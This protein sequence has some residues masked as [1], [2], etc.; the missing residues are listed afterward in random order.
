MHAVGFWHE[1]SRPDRDEH[2][3]IKWQNI[4]EGHKHNFW[5]IELSR[6]NMV[7]RYDMCSI[8]HYGLW[9]FGKYK[10]I[11]ENGRL[12]KSWHLQTILLKHE[13]YRKYCKIGIGYIGRRQN[14]SPGDIEKLNILYNCNSEKGKNLFCTQNQNHMSCMLNTPL[15]TGVQLRCPES[16]VSIKG[17]EG[18]KTFTKVTKWRTCSRKCRETIGCR[19]WT[20]YKWFKPLRLGSVCITY[21]DTDTKNVTSKIQYEGAISGARNCG[22]ITTDISIILD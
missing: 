13:R 22:S 1:Q 9:D 16:G 12:K 14:F 21:A 7:G 8:M 18:L 6:V 15:S 11:W 10:E 17:G 5:K 2:V 20:W 4:K 3:T 19:Y